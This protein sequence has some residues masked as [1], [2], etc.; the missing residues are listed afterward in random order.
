MSLSKPV[1]AS[2]AGGLPE[3]LG[4]TGRLLEVGDVTALAG[5]I[6]ELAE[7]PDLRTRMGAAGAPARR[8]NSAYRRWPVN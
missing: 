4:Q 7:A 6:L 3:V 8:L 2:T 1:I 5:A